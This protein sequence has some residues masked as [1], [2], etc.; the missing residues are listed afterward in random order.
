MT[1]CCDRLEVKN[2]KE[3][4]SGRRVN[5]GNVLTI[6][7]RRIGCGKQTAVS[8]SWILIFNRVITS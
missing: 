8:K 7:I 1:K 2:G 3:W 6:A 4:I 5:E